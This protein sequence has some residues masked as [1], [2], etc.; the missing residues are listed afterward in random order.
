M[1]SKGRAAGWGILLLLVI[2]VVGYLWMTHSQRQ[3]QKLI[4]VWKTGVHEIQFAEDHTFR[5][6]GGASPGSQGEYTTDFSQ[7]PAWINIVSKR[8]LAPLNM[9]PVYYFVG[10]PA[11]P[12]ARGLIRFKTRNEIELVF[13]NEYSHP[14]MPGVTN[15]LGDRRPTSFEPSSQTIIFTLTKMKQ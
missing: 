5:D 11:Q 13:I 9:T 6:L 12:L 15:G 8:N 7:K 10:M 14:N 3:E 1:R 4:G 2:L